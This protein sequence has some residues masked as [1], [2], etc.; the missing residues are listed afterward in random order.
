M[1][2]GADDP[3]IPVEHRAAFEDEMRAA[4]V[5]WQIHL[6]GGVVHSFTHPLASQAGIPGIAYDESAATQA[7][8]AMRALL[9]EV[10]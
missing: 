4:G 10:F 6:Y 5:D 2:I 1:C 7:W 9:A 8:G 3:I